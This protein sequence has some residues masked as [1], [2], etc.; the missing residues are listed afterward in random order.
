MDF[1]CDTGLVP[2]RPRGG[3]GYLA[4][5]AEGGGAKSNLGLEGFGGAIDDLAVMGMGP[6]TCETWSLL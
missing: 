2:E 6:G 3:S 1:Q 4:G 5:K